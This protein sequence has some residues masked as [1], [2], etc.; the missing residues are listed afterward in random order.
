M[1]PPAHE[2]TL[3]PLSDSAAYHLAWAESASADEDQEAFSIDSLPQDA[4]EKKFFEEV[5]NRCTGLPL[6]I[7]IVARTKAYHQLNWQQINESFSECFREGPAQG[8]AVIAAMELSVRM[9]PTELLRQQFLDLSIF[10]IGTYIPLAVLASLWNTK[11]AT[12][13]V[14]GPVGAFLC[15][16][17]VTWANDARTMIKLHDLVHEYFS[18]TIKGMRADLHCA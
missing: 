12:L 2:I 8:N 18:V 14:S 7:R 15:R 10:P 16:S 13:R 17:L 11:E 6:A 9:L 4:D 1:L 5:V 3:N